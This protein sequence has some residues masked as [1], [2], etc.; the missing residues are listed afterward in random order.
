MNI[1]MEESY[2]LNDSTWDDKEQIAI[3]RVLDSKMY[4]MGKEVEEFEVE[5]AKFTG[6]KHAIM[7]NSGSSANLLA[8]SALIYSGKIS[9]GD[10]VIVPAVSW[11]TTYFPLQQFGLKLIFVD[12][13]LDTLNMDLSAIEKAITPETKMIFAVNLLGNPNNFEIIQSICD[14]YKLILLED[15]CE[16]MGGMFLE[17]QL[18]TFGIMGTFSTFFSHHICTMEGGVVVTDHKDL[19]DYMLCIRAHGWTRN[20]PEDSNIY[21]KSSDPFY[22][23]FNFIVPGYNLRPLEQEGAIGKEQ[24]KKFPIFLENRRENAKYFCEKMEDMQ[25]VKLQE[26]FQYSSWFG[27]AIILVDHLEG[28]R[29]QIVD[30]L[31][32]KN[33]QLRPI[34]AGNFTKNPAIRYFDYTIS[35]VLSNSDY[36]HDN[37]FFIGNHSNDNKSKIDY[38]S[39]CFREILGELK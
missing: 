5:F 35:G 37:G 18:G 20:L 27:F 8:V 31:T 7:V 16:A 17:K 22:E 15:N 25:G 36:I 23:S 26:E 4:T 32:E 10:S 19:Y 28:K 14:K 24:L 9:P 29:D 21:Q 13:D 34:V 1:K 6:S 30:L 38:F 2:H 39:K 12:I 3:Q 11:S 33:I